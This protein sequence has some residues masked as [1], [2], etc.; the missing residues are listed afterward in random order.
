M[1][2]LKTEVDQVKDYSTLKP[3]KLLKFRDLYRQ[4]IY[5][6]D[7][8][9]LNIMKMGYQVESKFDATGVLAY[10][11]VDLDGA[12][13]FNVFSLVRMTD[14][15]IEEFNDDPMNKKIKHKI[16]LEDIYKSDALKVDLDPYKALDYLDRSVE[17]NKEHISTDDIE[18]LRLNQQIDDFRHYLNPD[19]LEAFVFNP[20][21]NSTEALW[22]TSLKMTDVGIISRVLTPVS[23]KFGIAVSDEKEFKLYK[24]ND[25]LK[26]IYIL[27]Q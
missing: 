11:Y 20:S 24:V 12:M 16:M 10:G 17:I 4:L 18:S 15:G 23:K 8:K 3:I 2:T 14:K 21:D 26:L 25:S 13:C 6:E 5:I 9:T 22:V 7:E 19:D 27:E 1:R